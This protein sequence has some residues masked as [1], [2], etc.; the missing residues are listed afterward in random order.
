LLGLP[1]SNK[2]FEYTTVTGE[3][4]NESE[5]YLTKL[6][7]ARKNYTTNWAFTPLFYARVG[8]WYKTN[9]DTVNF[10]FNN[11]SLN[12]LRYFFF[13]SSTY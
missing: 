13:K 11:L 8:I 12:H 7:K 2:P 5:T 6:A 1:Y 4:I 9:P 3:D 10:F